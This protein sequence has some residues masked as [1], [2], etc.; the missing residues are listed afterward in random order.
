ME[1]GSVIL[2]CQTLASNPLGGPLL[3][4][5]FSSFSHSKVLLSIVSILARES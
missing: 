1:G 2:T 3:P 5:A 4:H